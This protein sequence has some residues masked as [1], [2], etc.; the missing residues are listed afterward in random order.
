MH[1][2]FL[3]FDDKTGLDLKEQFMMEPLQNSI[4]LFGVV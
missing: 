3:H 2:L 4:P 1:D